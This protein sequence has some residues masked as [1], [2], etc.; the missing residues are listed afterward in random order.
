MSMRMFIACLAIL[1]FVA[2][3]PTGASDAGLEA[4]VSGVRNAK[5]QVGCL[6]F[7]SADG[8]PSDIKK[9]RQAVMAPIANGTALCR[10]EAPAGSYAIVAMHDE[11]SNGQLDKSLVGR[12]KEGYGASKGAQG[13]FGPKYEDARF[14]YR[15]GSMA[16]PISLRY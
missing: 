11:N 12:P 4:H 13:A 2:S 15:G 10:F 7:V 1:S 16:L 5:G 9:A 6:L 3:T 8:F 14:D